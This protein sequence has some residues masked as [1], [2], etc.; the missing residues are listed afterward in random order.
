MS[1]P[2]DVRAALCAAYGVKTMAELYETA[3]YKAALASAS[4]DQKRAV[5][6]LLTMKSTTSV[7]GF[8]VQ[9]YKYT[10]WNKAA[11]KSEVKSQ[12]P[13]ILIA[14]S[15]EMKTF[16]LKGEHKHPPVTP[17]TVGPLE[18]VRDI[19]KGIEVINPTDATTIKANPHGA[20]LPS[21][22]LEE[23]FQSC[24]SVNKR[25][26]MVGQTYTDS[27]VFATLTIGGPEDV[28]YIDGD[29]SYDGRAHLR[30]NMEDAD[31]R[32]VQA[33]LPIAQVRQTF[34]CGEDKQ[35]F[36][37]A[38]AHEPVAV[39]GQLKI[40]T[41]KG[42]EWFEEQGLKADL[43]AL[44]SDLY[45]NGCMTD[46][47]KAAD[48]S[49]LKAVD[50]KKV[51]ALEGEDCLHTVG[52]VDGKDVRVPTLMVGNQVRVYD[53]QENKKA[54]GEFFFFVMAEDLD[55]KPTFSVMPIE[56]ENA[57][58]SGTM[59]ADAYVA[60]INHLG[61]SSESEDRLLDDLLLG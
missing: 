3:A 33:E 9:H 27:P 8:Y 54:P 58:G 55:Y 40:L 5:Q 7:N 18:V 39:L 48:G 46:Y 17:V 1:N 13:R 24:W 38:L 45:S 15:G 53:I 43:D 41:A 12:G 19:R 42:A 35:E 14:S 52:Q 26:A 56:W 31:G 37:V 32:V 2:Q 4:G 44:M 49:Q 51:Q 16:Y 22:N 20:S 29:A 11:Q 6:S 60:F 61:V 47:K 30:A 10:R 57:T 23:A 59:N 50:M 28:S 36:C 21:L 25:G 34:G